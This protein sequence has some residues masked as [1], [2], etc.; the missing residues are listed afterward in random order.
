VRGGA[1]I[2]DYLARRAA[3]GAG[4]LVRERLSFDVVGLHKLNAVFP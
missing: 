3:M 4:S 1:H 2:G